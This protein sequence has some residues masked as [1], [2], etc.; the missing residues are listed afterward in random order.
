[1]EKR[2]CKTEMMD[3]TRDRIYSYRE[4]ITGEDN[5]G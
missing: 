4:G 2:T 5:T 1:M 3:G